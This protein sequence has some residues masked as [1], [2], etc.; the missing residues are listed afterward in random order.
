MEALMQMI[1]S[2]N[3]ELLIAVCIILIITILILITQTVKLSKVIKIQKELFSS[4][5]NINLE[6]MLLN[7]KNQVENVKKVQ[8][9]IYY[10]IRKIEKLLN[11]T[12]SKSEI[13]KYDAFADS[14]G[15][16]SFIYVLLNSYN[17]GI[18]LN[19][20]FSSEGHYLYIKD[21]VN[22]KTEKE[23]SKEERT[24]LEKAINNQ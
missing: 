7:Q 8:E 2:Y 10:N 5:N 3:N 12:Y 13:Y 21:V 19:G 22:G 1:E 4:K 24:T 11:K 6:E 9:D 17:S 14:A 23:L 18:I 15:K 20:I 16:L